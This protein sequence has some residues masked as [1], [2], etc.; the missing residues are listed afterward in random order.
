[1]NN[2]YKKMIY[3]IDTGI[4]LKLVVILNIIG[5]I[6]NYIN[7]DTNGILSNG[8]LAIILLLWENNY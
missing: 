1:M 4:L 8:F 5:I 3:F 2:I 6:V 7:N